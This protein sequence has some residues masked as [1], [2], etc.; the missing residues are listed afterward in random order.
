LNSRCRAKDGDAV[1]AFEACRSSCGSCGRECV[2]SPTWMK[3]A[4]EPEKD[5]DWSSRVKNRRITIGDDG[6]F[7]YESCLYSSRTCHY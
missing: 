3:S 6:A 1:F 2:D 5:C 4:E 7:A